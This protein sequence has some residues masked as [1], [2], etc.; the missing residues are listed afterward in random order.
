MKA[1]LPV[2]AALMTA[3]ALA[4]CSNTPGE[5]DSVALIDRFHAALNADDTPAIDALLSQS[6]RNLR[7]GIGTARA[8]RALSARHGRYLSGSI[9]KLAS[10][11]SRTTIAWSARYERGPVPEL[12]VLVTEGGA[13]KIDSY[14]DG[15][16]DG[17]RP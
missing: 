13:V 12:F 7:P 10:K 9:G 2:M 4:A 3:L 6:T 14:S 8:F 16:S 15:Y 1:L 17:A 11:D 5:A